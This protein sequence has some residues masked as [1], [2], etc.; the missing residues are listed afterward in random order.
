VLNGGAKVLYKKAKSIKTAGNIFKQAVDKLSSNYLYNESSCYFVIAS[1]AKQKKPSL[2][3]TK[4]SVLMFFSP[5]RLL[6]ASCLALAMTR[7]SFT[8]SLTFA[9]AD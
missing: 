8:S 9:M 7:F 4:Q 2:R 6:P 5:N 3:G 1:V